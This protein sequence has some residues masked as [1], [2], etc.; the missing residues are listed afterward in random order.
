MRKSIYKLFELNGEKLKQPLEV[1]IEQIEDKRWKASAGASS[2]VS[3]DRN[4]CL[5]KLIK[6]LETPKAKTKESK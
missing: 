1:L 3:P 2:A 4:E 6:L 5:Q